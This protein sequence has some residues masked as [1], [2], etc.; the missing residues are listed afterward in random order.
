VAVAT[1]VALGLTAGEI[2]AFRNTGQRLDD[3]ARSAFGSIRALTDAKALAY[4]ANADESRWLLD[5]ENQDRY[6]RTFLAESQAVADVGDVS[7]GGAGGAGGGLA[8]YEPRLRWM[9]L[10]GS[11]AATGVDLGMDS[12][13]GQELANITYPGESSAA[14]D[15]LSAYDAYQQGDARIRTQFDLS[16]PEG[17]RQAIDFDTDTRDAT[18]SDA[19]FSAFSDSL[20]RVIA[21]NQ[22]AFDASSAS[23]LGSLGPLAWLPWCEALAIV[24]LVAA[25]LRPRLVEFR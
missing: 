23:A 5:R 13:F 3:A 19:L 25:G 8:D 7:G 11:D 1:L 14:R 2:A 18:S 9:L 22:R 17:L 20:D 4:D 24:G 16:R 15:A 21:V 6:E 10:R 12:A